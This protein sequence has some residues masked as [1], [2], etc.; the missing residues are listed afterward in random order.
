MKKLFIVILLPFYL[1]IGS[2]NISILAPATPSS[3]PFLIASKRNDSLNTNLFMNH[4]K[5]HSKFL[6]KKVDILVTGLTVGKKFYDQDIPVKIINSYV[7]ELSY[8][9]SAGSKINNFSELKGKQIY[10]PFQGAPLTEVTKYFSR[11]ENL[12]WKKNL[13]PQ[14]SPFPSTVKLLLRGKAK[15]A[16]L[17]EPFISNLAS[18]NKNIHICFSY[19]KLWNKY[20]NDE[21]GFPQ[22]ATFI[23]SD[24]K[25]LNTKTIN[26][27]NT[28]LARS[29]QYIQNHP[30]KAIQQ[31]EKKYRF[32]KLILKNSLKR[33]NFL[34]HTGSKLKNEIKH[35]YK[36]IESPLDK[37]YQNF[38]LNHKK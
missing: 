10:L 16:V 3:L 33:T 11:Q 14:Y 26:T 19:T 29:I 20:S 12:K 22:V 23:K 35:Y 4:S 36:T 34:L 17:P 6:K 37:T 31:V 27:I 18:K 7:S 30:E 2:K 25:K 38:F 5:A 8:L 24:N 1:L 13:I 28:N 21:D 32:S 9:V 15:Y